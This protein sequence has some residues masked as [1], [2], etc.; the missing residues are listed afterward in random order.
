MNKMPS[1]CPVCEE[2]RM[3]LRMLEESKISVEEAE[4]LLGALDS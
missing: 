4:S 2:R 3:I 1:I